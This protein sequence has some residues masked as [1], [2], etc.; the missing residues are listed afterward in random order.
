MGKVQLTRFLDW[1]GLRGAPTL[2]KLS[3]GTQALAF[4]G[5]ILESGLHRPPRL[6]VG[7]LGATTLL[8]GGLLATNLAEATTFFSQTAATRGR[9]R[10]E[11]WSDG[12]GDS[13]P[14][15]ARV[16]AARVF[17]VVLALVGLLFIAAAWSGHT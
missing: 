7:I 9:S 8:L 13:V 5:V 15:L 3:I 17:G 10:A 1:L 4:V 14:L 11:F 12:S 16:G 6:T 2:L